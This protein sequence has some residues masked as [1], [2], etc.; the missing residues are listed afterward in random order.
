M[1]VCA[2][3][4]FEPGVTVEA[5]SLAADLH[6]PR[7]HVRSGRVHGHRAH[8]PRRRVDDELV[9]G[10]PARDFGAGGAPAQVPRSESEP[11]RAG[12]RCQGERRLAEGSGG[13]HVAAGTMPDGCRASAR[14]GRHVRARALDAGSGPGVASLG[15]SRRRH[16]GLHTPRPVGLDQG[17]AATDRGLTAPADAARSSYTTTDHRVPSA[18]AQY[19]WQETWWPEATALS[20]GSTREHCSMANGPRGWKWHPEGGSIGDGTS[21]LRIMSSRG[22]SGSAGSAAAKSAFV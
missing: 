18:P 11:V 13:D 20:A 6:D 5:A 8:G 21:P 10:P 22:A 19:R 16:A 1:D 15:V 7:P 17:R 4:I 14:L 9:S 12:G 3:Q 2:N